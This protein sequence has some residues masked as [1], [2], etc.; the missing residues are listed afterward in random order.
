[1]ATPR[2][3]EAGRETDVSTGRL[4]VSVQPLLGGPVSRRPPGLTILLVLRQKLRDPIVRGLPNYGNLI[5]LFSSS[6]LTA[7][8]PSWDLLRDF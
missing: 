6:A 8:V 1:M 3:S 5:N 7:F 2:G 4:T